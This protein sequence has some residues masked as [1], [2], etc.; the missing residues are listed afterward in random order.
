[1]AKHG[2]GGNIK[3][4]FYMEGR[5]IEN[6]LA[7]IQVA[8]NTGQPATAQ[9][10]LTPTNTIKHIMPG[11]WVHVFTTDP[12]DLEPYG[13]L[14]DFK[15]LFEGVV[16]A[17]GFTKQDDGR[18]LTVQCADP[19][20]YWVEARQ[21]WMNLASSNGNIVDEMI[22][23][24]SGG[25]GRIGTV[26]SDGVKGFLVKELGKVL[27]DN[28][29]HFMDALLSSIDGI[30]NVNPFYTN[31][32]NR[33]R[34]TDRIL[35]GPAGKTEKLFTLALLSE[36]ID[37]L[38]GRMSGQ[39][40]LAEVVN[41]LLSSIMHEWVSVVAPP[42]VSADIFERDV[43]GNIKRSPQTR[44]KKDPKGRRKVIRYRYRMAEEK[45]VASMI[46]KPHVYT[47]SPPTCNILFPNMFDQLT[48]NESF[49]SEPTR[50]V[51]R[52]QI[53]LLGRK[54]K[55]QML[56]LLRPTEMEI[57]TSIIHDK[58][59]K[60]A[61]R[62]T[63]DG[64]YAD[65]YGQTPTFHDYDWTTNEERI[66]GIVPSFLNMAPAPS[67]LT[68][69]DPGKRQPTGS[70]KGGV[71]KYLQNVAS[72]E[73]YK[74][75]F[76]SRQT[77][78]AGPYNMRPVPGFPILALDDSDANMSIVAYLASVVHSIDADG[79][80]MTQYAIQFP[81]LVDEVD[82]N[83]P[84][85][86]ANVAK[87]R[88]FLDLFRGD[89][90]EYAFEGM[91]DGL[92]KPAIPEWFDESFR[93]LDRLD[94]TYN[95]WFGKSC[96]TAENVLFEKADSDSDAT[97]VEETNN[98]VDLAD[99]VK[100]L[101]S[102]YRN[103]RIWGRE[104]IEASERT[105]RAFTRID[106]A[107][108][109]VGAGPLE[110]ADQG[111]REMTEE[112]AR[113]RFLSEAADSRYINYATMKMDVFTGDTSH[114]S[115]YSASPLASERG[116]AAKTSSGTISD[117]EA[118]SIIDDTLDVMSGAFPVF[119]TE[120]HT[121]DAATN[122]ATRDDL[123]K[124]GDKRS[125]SKYA[126]YD[127]RPLMYDFEYRL[128]KESVVTS[129]AFKDFNTESLGGKYKVSGGGLVDKVSGEDL[130]AFAEAQKQAREAAT[131]AQIAATSEGNPAPEDTKNMTP[132]QQA[133]T[134]DSAESSERLPLPQPLSEK[135]VVDLRRAVVDAYIE[136]L[137][138][139]RGF[140]G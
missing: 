61:K 54:N 126:R 21:Y 107:F 51:M 79:N 128:W 6:G 89:D 57:Y 91:F 12:W 132:D 62:R 119:D 114:G 16:V 68:I 40:N 122:Q 125:K 74:A 77:T 30:G 18:S 115:G 104:F 50:I 56:Q 133:P 3:V 96:G 35:R 117:E 131:S 9:L 34:L 37:A 70:R 120:L 4:R 82:F 84:V 27:E 69:S 135:Q 25:Y 98:S 44:S 39:T 86:L 59:R 108:K 130:A 45:I 124:D 90:G 26:T 1:M 110:K 129:G 137:A 24:T 41:T 123:L 60:T 72:Y 2:T 113:D 97:A 139:T 23:A 83:R 13:D 112:E 85:Q 73:Y 42:Y 71:P 53:P 7:S 103:A 32:R 22:T 29:E 65:G 134:G 99:A 127:G 52:P 140:T 38:A 49:L 58:D 14:R 64:K 102:I 75:K 116:Q 100:K 111:R 15:L 28:E 20:V 47:L 31:I 5:L 19:S 43:F 121:G 87:N 92:N 55:L 63:P 78:L 109:F 36:F 138:R 80:A 88:S 48:Y 8:G 46:F 106:E 93:E 66:R 94:Y 118:L 10:E 11:T 136:E 17:R 33:F 76:A 67:T 105:D 81:R 101:N 95:E